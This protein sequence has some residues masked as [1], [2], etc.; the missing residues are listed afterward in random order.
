MAV[1][2]C[3]IS[4]WEYWRTPPVVAGH[5]SC[6]AGHHAPDAHDHSSDDSQKGTIPKLRANARKVDAL[7]QPRLLA[8]LKGL[9]LPVHVLTD[10]P[11][12]F[13]PTSIAKPAGI[14]HGFRPH[15]AVDI[16]GGLSVL[17]PEAT[18]LMQP[19]HRSSHL[20]DA[21]LL[22]KMMFEATGI[23]TIPPTGERVRQAIEDLWGLGAF[24][25]GR[26]ASE[27][28][29]GF[30]DANGR[31]LGDHDRWGNRIEWRPILDKRGGQTNMWKR[32]PLTSVEE[33]GSLL[34]TLDP[35][36]RSRSFSVVRRALA[37][38]RN[39]AASP[40]EVQANL[41]LCSTT[42]N[43][44]ESWGDPFL[45]RHVHFTDNARKLAHASFAIADSIWPEHRSILEVQGEEYHTDDLGYRLLSGRTAA[46]ESMGYS[47]AEIL[48]FQMADLELFDAIL[49][50]LG[51]RLGFS[52]CKPTAA[53][54]RRRDELHHELFSMPYEPTATA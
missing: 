35:T 33:L 18:L 25:E 3:D 45:N 54:L 8:D 38:T 31:P 7:I 47:I 50:S 53:H 5:P 16:G 44:G 39:G 13:H 1:I 12:G 2:I 30:S 15:C 24:E 46:L 4:A 40:A 28:V 11:A 26:L 34:A 6:G 36:G 23:F 37:M 17:S 9:S 29:Y 21:A 48:P 10:E 20:S 32:P 51:K 14:P 22:S 19:R 49:T 41:L 42:H 27:G 52:P 43:G